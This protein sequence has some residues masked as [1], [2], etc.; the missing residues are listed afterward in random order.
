[1]RGDGAAGDEGG[2]TTDTTAKKSNYRTVVRGRI[3]RR[4]IEA[5]FPDPK[6]YGERVK[7]F[8]CGPSSMYDAICGPRDRE[9]ITGILG[10][11]GYGP[12]Q[13]YKF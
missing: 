11:M 13:V 1:M 7:I 3:D 8:F 6:R 2:S 9:E 12:E 4:M 5:R 10:E